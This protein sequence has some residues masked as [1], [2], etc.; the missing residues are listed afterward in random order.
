MLFGLM[1]D[2]FHQGQEDHWGSFRVRMLEAFF[3]AQAHMVHG[4]PLGALSATATHSEV[5]QVIAC[6]GRRKKGLDKCKCLS[7]I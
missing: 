5:D 6:F 4:S 7:E 3:D 1:Q 2:E